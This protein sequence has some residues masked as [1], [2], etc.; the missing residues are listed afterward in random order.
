MSILNNIYNKQLLTEIHKYNHLRISQTAFANNNDLQYDVI[1]HDRYIVVNER[2]IKI[3]GPLKAGIYYFYDHIFLLDIDM[4]EDEYIEYIKDTKFIH[5]VRPNKSRY[6][7][8]LF[9][10]C[11]TAIDTKTNTSLLKYT[12]NCNA[13]KLFITGNTDVVI[14]KGSTQSPTN[15]AKLVSITNINI[16]SEAVNKNKDELPI[17]AK[18]SS[19]LNIV[20]R[21]G[22]KSLPSGIGDTLVIDNVKHKAYRIDK[23]GRMVFTGHE[24]WRLVDDLCVAGNNG[25]SVYFFNTS[26]PVVGNNTLDVVCSHFPTISN[27]EMFTEGGLSYAISTSNDV[28]NNGFYVRV[29]NSIAYSDVDKFTEWLANESSSNTIFVEYHMKDYLWKEVQLDSFGLRLF[30][31][32]TNITSSIASNKITVLCKTIGINYGNFIPTG[33]ALDAIDAVKY[34]YGDTYYYS[35]GGSLYKYDQNDVRLYA[36]YD[37]YY[38]EGN[39]VTTIDSPNQESYP[40]EDKYDPE[41]YLNYRI[42]TSQQ[43]PILDNNGYIPIGGIIRWYAKDKI[44]DG[45]IYYK[46]DEL[47]RTEYKELFEIYGT[48]FGKGD[49]STTFNLPNQD[50]NEENITQEEIDSIGF[51]FLMC[52]K[53]K[54]SLPIGACLLWYGDYHL[55]PLGFIQADGSSI[56]KIDYY[57]LY[58]LFGDRYGETDIDKFVL[59]NQNIYEY[60]NKILDAEGLEN[61]SY[62]IKAL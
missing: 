12:V 32:G 28:N 38:G 26:Y 29:P 57:E 14:K 4:K 56:S 34:P 46:G 40:I 27:S 1:L 3:P 41:D 25:Y 48:T 47:S 2:L 53:P 60:D 13:D 10:I 7:L 59:P 39:G 35:K 45:F 61:F 20:L 37:K 22:L 54:V 30:Y 6:C 58:D 19:E 21:N 36:A 52:I 15:V 16:K 50:Y 42:F 49:G 31:G 11:G 43:K 8:S 9:K 55:P 23:I 44:P 18:L 24:D 51:I 33:A 5:I 17:N 62:V